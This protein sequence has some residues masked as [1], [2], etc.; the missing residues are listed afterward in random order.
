MTDS[1]AQFQSADVGEAD[2][3]AARAFAALGTA[4]SAAWYARASV[5]A[6]TVGAGATNPLTLQARALADSLARRPALAAPTRKGE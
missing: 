1:I 5:P 4:D 3:L 2:F 6:L